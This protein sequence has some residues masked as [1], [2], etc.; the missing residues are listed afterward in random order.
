VSDQQLVRGNE[1]CVLGAIAA[2]CRFY[3]GYP[4]TPSS[5]VAEG[6]A[7][8]LPG[9]DGVFVQ[10]EDEISSLAAVIGASLGGVKGMTATSGP[11][12]SLMQEHV[13]YAA[14]AEIPCVIVNVMRGGP[15]T[16]MPTSPSQGDVMQAR[17]GTHGDHPAIVLAPASVRE[18][19]ELT[20]RAFNLAERF[21]TPVQVVY[22]EVIGHIA[23]RVDLPDVVEVTDRIRPVSAP[24][25]YL[26]YAANGN[27]VP[28]MAAFGDGYRFHVTGLS[29]DERG[30]PTTD[31]QTSG[32]LLA[33]LQ[34]KV[35]EHLDEIVEVEEFGTE[36][37]EV[38][39]FAYGITARAAR[40][41]VDR[42]RAAGVR[43][44][45]LRPRT[46]WPFPDA[47]VAAVAQRT[48][49]LLVAEMNLGQMVHEVT[50]AAAG[51][52]TVTSLLRADSEPITPSQITDRLLA[53]P[54][55]AGVQP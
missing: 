50:R 42:A 16:G 22:D 49:N 32:R 18:V 26:P 27:G 19:F 54:A 17:W 14:M 12:Y 31:P 34:S 15:S 37:A 11:G 52:T 6:M 48:P 33:R 5:E 8:R 51:A 55:A 40:D 10:M 35:D 20:V 7:R 30:F 45:L 23:E 4:I 39:V 28:P 2:G 25:D 44:G 38:V 9:L 3:A 46:L 47:A 53:L 1:A 21:R 29:H 36:D 41:A 13:G 24:A 43:V